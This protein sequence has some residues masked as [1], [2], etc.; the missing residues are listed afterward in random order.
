MEVYFL[1]IYKSFLSVII[2]FIL[3]WEILKQTNGKIYH[4]KSFN[5]G[6]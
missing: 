4:F 6:K 3:Y 2:N 5:F 1:I